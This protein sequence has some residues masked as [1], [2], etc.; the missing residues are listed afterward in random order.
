MCQIQKLR[1]HF[2]HSGYMG[3]QKGKQ[4]ENVV[5]Q[6][7]QLRL[8]TIMMQLKGS[9]TPATYT[10]YRVLCEFIRERRFLN[11]SLAVS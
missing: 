10:H 5:L 1:E 9:K 8:F 4:Q 2:H 11:K 7:I 6:S 3:L